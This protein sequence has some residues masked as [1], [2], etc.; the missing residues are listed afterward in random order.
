M[1]ELDGFK[2]RAAETLD[3]CADDLIAQPSD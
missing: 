3:I 2:E 1:I